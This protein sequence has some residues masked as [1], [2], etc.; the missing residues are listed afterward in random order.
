MQKQAKA[1]IKG[2][3]SAFFVAEAS[4][5]NC[6]RQVFDLEKGTDGDSVLKKP[7]ERCGHRL[8]AASGRHRTTGNTP[9]PD[10]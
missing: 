8:R 5:G 7:T 10:G 3:L 2:V 9:E 4:A 6:R 1:P